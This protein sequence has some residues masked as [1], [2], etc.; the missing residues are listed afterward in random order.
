M[1]FKVK[2]VGVQWEPPDPDWYQDLGQV[3]GLGP[4][5]AMSSFRGQRGHKEVG[6]QCDRTETT[7]F[8]VQ[9]DL[10]TQALSGPSLMLQCVSVRA[11]GPGE[12]TL[13]QHYQKP[14][15]RGRPRLNRD[16]TGSRPEPQ[17]QTRTRPETGDQ[18][19][20]RP[21]AEDQNQGDQNRTISDTEDQTRAKTRTR[22]REIRPSRRYQDYET[23]ES[24]ERKRRRGAED[25]RDTAVSKS[26]DEDESVLKFAEEES[27]TRDDPNWTLRNRAAPQ[28]FVSHDAAVHVKE[29]AGLVSAGGVVCDVCG[30]V[31]KTK[32]SLSRHA[33]VHS[34]KQPH[35][36]R[37][38]PLRFNRK[39]NLRHH[40]RIMHPNGPAP[41]VKLRPP[42]ITWLCHT[43]G[44][45]FT[46]RS[47]LKTHEQIHTGIKPC[48]CP[49]CPK[50]YMR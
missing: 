35:S 11:E 24:P 18:T 20:T 27:R 50:A 42:P 38:C 2:D 9:V 22:T 10:I 36:C 43:C 45:T 41:R 17:D 1:D 19:R 5:E 28:N 37:F 4:G 23:P 15:P 8:G 26:I 34:G 12:G 47:R 39:D 48:Q 16:Q 30:K 13:L 44:K 6:V 14:R 3:L 49:L 40:L 46:H 32:S 29:E 25:G 31:L 7:E 21:E 33:L